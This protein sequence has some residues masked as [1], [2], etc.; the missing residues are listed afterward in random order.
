MGV[1]AICKKVKES[2]SFVPTECSISVEQIDQKT[3]LGQAIVKDQHYFL[4]RVNEMFLSYKRK[5]F[6]TY[7]PVVFS[8]VE[9]LYSS[10][11]VSQPFL[12]SPTMLQTPF[13][14]LNEGMLFRDTSVAG[15]QPYRGGRFGLTMVLGRLRQ[16]NYLRKILSLLEDTVT[17]FP[18]GFSTV[19]SG[20][21]KIAN[22]VLDNIETLFDSQDIEAVMGYRQEFVPA[23]QDN[24]FTGYR[25]L[26]NSDEGKLDRSRFFVRNNSLYYGQSL[27][28][29]EPYRRDD[30]ILYSMMAA[31]HRDDTESLPFHQQYLELQKMIAGMVELSGDERKLIN[32]KLFS[33]QDAVRMSADLV[34]PQI[35]DQINLYRQDLKEMID[36]RKPL[37][38]ARGIH[39]NGKDEWEK[40]MDSLGL[41]LLNLN[42]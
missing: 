6:S 15:L 5:W 38:S 13:K 11:R 39:Q 21:S 12:I 34:R 17:A 29:S 4:V 32:G 19:I 22:M 42:Y 24:F 37:S 26:M 3:G 7:D 31:T 2:P 35:I 18:S 16:E 23:V 14:K 33:L 27:E 28:D 10:Q 40:E 25:V 9:Y 8:N 30:Y 20:Y 36:A 41:E 1:T